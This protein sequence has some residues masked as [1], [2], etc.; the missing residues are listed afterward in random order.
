MPDKQY[1]GLGNHE[2]TSLRGIAKRAKACG[3][4]RFQNLYRM[5]DEKLLHECWSDLNKKAASGVDGVTAEQYEVNLA[6]NILDLAQ[7]LKTKRYLTKL[8]R[9]VYI[10]KGGGKVRPL[11]IPALE[12]KLVQLCCAR[13]LTSIYEQ[14]F[15]PM[16]Y[17]YR[18]GKSARDASD[19]LCF[20]LQYCERR[21]V[22]PKPNTQQ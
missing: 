9:R 8:V 16:S 2:T 5:I 7:R 15:L 22:L 6:E 12:D 11:G 19:D 13:I 21:R 17:G 1:V 3:Q 18:K 10:P 14:E 20:N 4:H